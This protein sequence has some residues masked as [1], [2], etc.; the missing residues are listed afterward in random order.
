MKHY[1]QL[2]IIL[3]TLMTQNVFTTRV[4]VLHKLIKMLSVYVDVC[5]GLST[6]SNRCTQKLVI[7]HAQTY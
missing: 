2:L 3:H 5:V 4:N 7:S 6:N 1:A